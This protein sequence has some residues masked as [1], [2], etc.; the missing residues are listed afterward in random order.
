MALKLANRDTFSEPLVIDIL[1]VWQIE[2]RHRECEG[3]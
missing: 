1:R 2:A 3:K